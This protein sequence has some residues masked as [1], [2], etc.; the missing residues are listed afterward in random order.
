MS[1]RENVI[2]LVLSEDDPKILRKYLLDNLDKLPISLIEI[3]AHNINRLENRIYPKVKSI[4][5]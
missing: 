3:L 1:I 5:D 2:N 4:F